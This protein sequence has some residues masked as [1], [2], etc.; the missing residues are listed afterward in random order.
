M[1]LEKEVDQTFKVGDYN[2]TME[3]RIALRKKFD[4]NNS[5]F[6]TFHEFASSSQVMYGSTL[7]VRWGKMVLVIEPDGH[8]HS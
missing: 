8:C 1:Q 5:G 7:A 6:H 3:Q 2:P 4:Q